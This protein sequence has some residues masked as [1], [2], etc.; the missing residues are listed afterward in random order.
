MSTALLRSYTWIIPPYNLDGSGGG[1]PILVFS[2]FVNGPHIQPK[3]KFLNV[4]Q[5]LD[6]LLLYS[7]EIIEENEMEIQSR[8]ITQNIN[9]L[10]PILLII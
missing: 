9:P 2:F 10:F 5:G 6:L 8:Q 1:P 3:P 4:S 7:S